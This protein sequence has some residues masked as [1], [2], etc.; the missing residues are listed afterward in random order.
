ME[1]TTSPPNL[2]SNGNISTA[3][4]PTASQPSVSRT[5]S[6]SPR[7]STLEIAILACYPVTM[8]LGI[9]SN[10]PKDSYF[11]RK[12]NFINVFFLKYSWAWTSLVFF[13]HLS[14]VPNKVRPIARYATATIW[15]YLVSQW[16]FGPPIMDKV[17]KLLN[18]VDLRYSEGQVEYV[19]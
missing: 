18:Q 9:I 6:L 13:W 11:A 10:H 15:W 16:C 4:A 12:D 19:N 14:R 3:K 8:L 2:P 17:S 1:P 5:P 7:L